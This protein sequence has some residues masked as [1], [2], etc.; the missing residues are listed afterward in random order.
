M[1]MEGYDR[2]MEQRRQRDVNKKLKEYP[3]NFV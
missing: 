1:N 3:Y 2:D